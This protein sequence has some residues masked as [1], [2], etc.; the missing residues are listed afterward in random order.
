MK[1]QRI[2]LVG[3]LTMGPSVAV[4]QDPSDKNDRPNRPGAGQRLRNQRG[5]EGPVREMLAPEMM[6][7]G[8]A[9]MAKNF[10]IMKALDLDENGQLSANE[11]ENASKSLLKLDKDGDGM[12]S[13]E[14]M[15]P[16]PGP[17]MN[18][19]GPGGPM[20][21]GGPGGGGPG[22]GPGAMLRMFQ[23]RDKDGDGKLTGDEI[24]EPMRARVGMM[25]ENGDG[26]IDKSEIEKAMSRMQGRGPG[27]RRD[28]PSGG[29][30]GVAP[31]RPPR[32]DEDP[33][34][35]DKD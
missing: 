29:G 9:M 25:D 24:P 28:R 4:A 6:G 19:A 31:K 16:E 22:A 18:L 5:G 35:K 11:I 23:N 27:D 13:E 3:V 21:P 26:S 2:M 7:R 8:L 17:W 33:D 15:R 32:G 12:L 1:W 34:K 14:E 30:E 10:P 20:G